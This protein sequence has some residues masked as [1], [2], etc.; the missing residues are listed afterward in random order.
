MRIIGFNLSKIVAEKKEKSVEKV[1]INQNI[2]IKDVIKEK[3]PISQGEALS[4]KFL[5]TID[6]SEDFAKVEFGGNVLLLPEKDELKTFLKEWKDKKV[7][8]EFRTPLFNFI[9]SKCNIKALNL[10]EELSLPHH[11]PMP[12]IDAG[13]Q[14]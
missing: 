4:V 7:P 9:M 11:V 6:Y 1:Q 14:I 13:S 10:E 2:N 5:F 12:R 3:I 8:E